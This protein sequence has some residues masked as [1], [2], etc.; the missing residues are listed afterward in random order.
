MLTIAKDKKFRNGPNTKATGSTQASVSAKIKPDDAIIVERA[1]E[2]SESEETSIIERAED[3]PL[4]AMGEAGPTKAEDSFTRTRIASDALR[5]Q[6][7]V[8][9]L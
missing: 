2:V 9:I 5:K 1:L 6:F 3:A 7:I 8:K 4:D